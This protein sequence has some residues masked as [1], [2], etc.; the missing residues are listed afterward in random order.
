MKCGP[1]F[2]RCAPPVGFIIPIIKHEVDATWTLLTHGD[3]KAYE[4]K[5]GSYA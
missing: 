1:T 3:H 4:G 2:G 5:E